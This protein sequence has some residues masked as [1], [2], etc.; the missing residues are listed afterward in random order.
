MRHF[1]K[2]AFTPWA[3]TLNFLS[4]TFRAKAVVAP[5][6]FLLSATAVSWG[7]VAKFW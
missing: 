4:E 7:Y 2:P 5:Q 6:V 1:S 3:V